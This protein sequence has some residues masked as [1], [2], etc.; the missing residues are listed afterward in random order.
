VTSIESQSKYGDAHQ[1]VLRGASPH[2]GPTHSREALDRSGRASP[3]T[4]RIC[5][6]LDRNEVHLTMGCAAETCEVYILP[7]Q[8]DVALNEFVFTINL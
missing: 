8:S 2:F 4:A 7:R 3:E 5:V 1:K 6:D